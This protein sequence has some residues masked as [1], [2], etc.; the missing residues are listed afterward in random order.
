MISL[1]FLLVIL[2]VLLY[3]LE[4]YIPMSQPIKIA[5]RVVVAMCIGFYLLRIF[6]VADIP[7]PQVR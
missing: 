5:I 6:G 2:G 1:I 4:A 7:I 3:F